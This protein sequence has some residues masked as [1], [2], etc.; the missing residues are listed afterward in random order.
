[1]VF[2]EYKEKGVEENICTAKGGR[3]WRPGK[4]A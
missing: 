4:T 3:G 2:R 1:M